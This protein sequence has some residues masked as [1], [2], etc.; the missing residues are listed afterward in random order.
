MIDFNFFFLFALLFSIFLLFFRAVSLSS[1]LFAS[2][3]SSFFCYSY[4]HNTEDLVMYQEFLFNANILA[5]KLH[6]YKCGYVNV[7]LFRCF[8]LFFSYA[9]FW[10]NFLRFFFLSFSSLLHQHF[11]FDKACD[12]WKRCVFSLSL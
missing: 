12:F 3:R 8:L 2:R 7:F 10:Y 9:H 11:L 5:D 1:F 6:V 4:T